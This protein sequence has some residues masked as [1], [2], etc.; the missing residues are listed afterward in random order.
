MLSQPSDKS[1]DEQPP[2]DPND[3]NHKINLQKQPKT[4]HLKVKGTSSRQGLPPT[5]TRAIQ[6]HKLNR[7]CFF[8]LHKPS[9][10]FTTGE[11][12]AEKS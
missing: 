9:N 4:A 5:H 6:R 12:C 2:A 1:T 10:S 8:T 3:S 7:N 11:K